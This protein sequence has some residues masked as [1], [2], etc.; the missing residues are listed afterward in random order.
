MLSLQLRKVLLP[1][2]KSPTVAATP[3]AA[4]APPEPEP[5]PRSAPV[6]AEPAAR[7][8][9][10]ARPD[11]DGRPPEPP[12]GRSHPKLPPLE[13]R[14]APV[15][16]VSPSG[17]AV[18]PPTRSSGVGEWQGDSAASG[19]G[20]SAAVLPVVLVVVRVAMPV[21][22]VVA[23]VPLVPVAAPVA[24]PA[25]VLVVVRAS[26][27]R[28]VAGPRVAPASSRRR[29]Q[30]DLA[31]PGQRTRHRRPRSE[32]RDRHRARR[33]GAGVRP[34]LNRTAADVSVP[35]CNNGEMVTAR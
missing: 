3:A 2:G 8:I 22:P 23:L 4:P 17:K 12:L 24:A 10:S 29:D 1:V 31:A 30:D 20:A 16:P 35:C 28:S 7:V 5:E 32:R 19:V 21:V 25:A 26:G 27:R 14:P 9:S 6:A 15:R 33:V 13:R 18:P 34:K 11:A